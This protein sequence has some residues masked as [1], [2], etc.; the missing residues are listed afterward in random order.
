ME[1]P[2]HC[3]Y[4]EVVSNVLGGD[5]GRFWDDACAGPFVPPVDLQDLPVH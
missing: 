3:P 5:L 1:F 2:A 4:A